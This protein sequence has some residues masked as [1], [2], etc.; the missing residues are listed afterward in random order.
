MGFFE[1]FDEKLHL[2]ALEKVQLQTKGLKLELKDIRRQIDSTLCFKN[3]RVIVHCADFAHLSACESI[4]NTQNSLTAFWPQADCKKTICLKCLHKLQYQ[5]FDL[6]KN[7]RQ[8]H[9][10][11]VLKNFQFE[12][13]FQSFLLYPL[14]LELHPSIE[15][16]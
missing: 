3:G 8:I 14:L 11:K 16:C 10:K 12:I 2:S 9:N 6:Y 15:I 4:I 5:G 13:F 1:S 7:R